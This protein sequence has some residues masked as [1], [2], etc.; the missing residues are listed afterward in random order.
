MIID[1]AHVIAVILVLSFIGTSIT[2]M[3]LRKYSEHQKKQKWKDDE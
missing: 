3:A 1:I 2:F